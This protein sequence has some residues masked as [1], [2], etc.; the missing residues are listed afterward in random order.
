MTN[1]NTDIGVALYRT[2]LGVLEEGS[3]SGAARSMGIAQPTVGRH[4][5]ALE[6]ALGVTLFTRSQTGLLPTEAALA[7]QPF[8]LTGT[9]LPLR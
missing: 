4:V 6:T 7:L 2:F 5:D 3:L 9:A 8:A 1:N